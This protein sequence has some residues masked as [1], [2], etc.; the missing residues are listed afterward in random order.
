MTTTTISSDETRTEGVSLVGGDGL[1]VENG[2]TLATSGAAAVAWK[3]G[4]GL[5]TVDI[6]GEVLASGGRGID[7]SGTL[8]SGSQISVVVEGAGRLASSD[9]AIRVKNNFTSGTIEIDNSGS[10][11]SADIDAAG[12]NVASPASSGQAID[13]TAITST[14]TTIVIRNQEGGVISAA[15]ADAIRP[16]ANTRIINAGTVTA[17]A[18]NGNTSSDG[19]DFQDTGSGTVTNEATGSIIGARHGITAKTAISVTNSGTIQGQLGSGINLDT[20]SGVAVIENA[21]GGLIEGT[22]SG[23]R[24]G[25]GIDVDYLAT[26]INSGTIRAAGVSSDS[27]TL[28]EAITIGGGTITNASG[29]LIVSTQRAITVDDSNG[30]GAYGAT[31]ITNAGTIEGGN[32]EAISIVGTFGDTLTNSGSIIGGVALAG[33]DDVLTNT[34][35]ISGAVSLGEGN[36]TFNAGT[37]S[38][39]GGTI[40]GGDGNDVINLSGSGTGT[41][42]N[43]TSFESLN[44]ERGDWSLIGAQSYVS[45]VTIAADAILEIV[46]GAS[47]TGAIT[48]S[49]TLSVDGVAVSD[50][51]VSAGGSLVVSSGGSAD[52]SVLVGGEAWVLSGGR[53]NGTSVSDGGTE[54]VAGGVATGTTLSGGSQIVEAG[55]T[56]SGTLV[57]SGGVLDVSDAGTAVGAAVTD[58]GTAASYWGGTLNGTT[59]ANGGVVSA[60]SD[61]T[62]NGSTVNLGGTLVV[63]SGGVASGSTVNDGG[64]AWVRDGGS[65]S[66]TVVTSGGGVMVEQ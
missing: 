62:L 27:G 42:A 36:D 43:V 8:A 13:L 64:A 39:V 47:V 38:T 5:T 14:S 54:W 40:D 22:A 51:T 52:G 26:V 49:G 44:V 2:G 7:A 25:D 10:I 18:E 41:L 57:G 21:P 15:D 60:F 1:I 61:G 12:K 6:G 66:D 48:V 32:G 63:S 9:D 11:V 20:T 31:T 4:S 55:G 24:D 3:G 53:T 56:A 33:G 16:G 30:G 35:T 45:G 65:L 28:S 29:G 59:V 34:G 58:G 50:T 46:S 19:I 23:S 17:L 37:G